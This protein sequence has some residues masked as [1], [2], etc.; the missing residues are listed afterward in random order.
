MPKQNAIWVKGHVPGYRGNY[1]FVT[2]TKVRPYWPK[3]P[4]FPTHI[5]EEGM[6][7]MMFGPPH[8]LFLIAGIFCCHAVLFCPLNVCVQA[9]FRKMNWLLQL[10][11]PG[12]VN[13][14]TTRAS[15][16]AKIWREFWR[17]LVRNTVNSILERPVV[18]SKSQKK[19]K[20]K[21]QSSQK[22]ISNVIANHRFHCFF[23][24]SRHTAH[25]TD[26]EK[27]MHAVMQ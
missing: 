5:P 1:V 16:R 4:P 17:K 3:P 12:L 2:D 10:L 21:S 9:M 26:C 22:S 11:H 20:K 18:T 6:H 27:C 24:S 13:L 23:F 8:L 15:Q 7:T 14:E 19:K 25:S